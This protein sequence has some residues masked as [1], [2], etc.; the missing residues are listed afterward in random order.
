VFCVCID[1][2]QQARFT[3][4]VTIPIGSTAIVAM[5]LMGIDQRYAAVTESDRRVW[6]N[7]AFVSG[8]AGVGGATVVNGGFVEFNVTSGGT[9]RFDLRD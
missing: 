5:P 4:T 6:F 7:N 2:D 1:G 3:Y 9:Y 8:V